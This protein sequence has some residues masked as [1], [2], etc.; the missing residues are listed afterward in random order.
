[1][2]SPHG[3]IKCSMYYLES[4]LTVRIF[5]SENQQRL[6]WQT[7]TTFKSMSHCGISVS[8]PIVA[9]LINSKGSLNGESAK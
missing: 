1:M 5:Y 7:V 3:D 6:K 9:R 2:S 4:K 8:A